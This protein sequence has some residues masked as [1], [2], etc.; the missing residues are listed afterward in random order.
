MIERQLQRSRARLPFIL[1]ANRQHAEHVSSAALDARVY[2]IRG[3]DCA[4]QVP[5]V[6]A[7]RIVSKV[8]TPLTNALTPSRV[9]PCRCRCRPCAPGAAQR[10]HAVAQAAAYVLQHR[11]QRVR[12]V[13]AAVWFTIG[14][15]LRCSGS[16][17]SWRVLL[18]WLHSNSAS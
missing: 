9:Q 8:S 5:Y 11:A 12:R 17:I 10:R 7:E 6:T 3:S 1:E 2:S 15:R 16:V 14:S 18:Q 4:C 13:C